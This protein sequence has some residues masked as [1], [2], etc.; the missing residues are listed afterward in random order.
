MK[1]IPKKG[2]QSQPLLSYSSYSWGDPY[3]KPP[4][5]GR[6]GWSSPGGWPHL[7][8]S[9]ILIIWKH[10]KTPGEFVLRHHILKTP[11]LKDTNYKNY[12]NLSYI[13]T[14]VFF[15]FYMNLHSIILMFHISWWIMDGNGGIV[16]PASPSE[17]VCNLVYRPYYIATIIFLW[18]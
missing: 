13:K 3:A 11:V 16:Q 6:L 17:V 12:R 15:C 2:R 4:A 5:L 10:G 14:P 18:N 1:Q 8:E 9:Q 7:Q